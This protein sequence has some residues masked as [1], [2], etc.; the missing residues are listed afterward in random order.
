M[1]ED[2]NAIKS[3]PSSARQRNAIEM[4]FRWRAFN[5]PSLNTVLVAMYFLQRAVQ[6]QSNQGLVILAGLG[7]FSVF[8]PIINI[9]RTD[10][11]SLLKTYAVFAHAHISCVGK[12]KKLVWV[13]SFD[14]V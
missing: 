9:E 10:F 11:T 14:Q 6:P 5:G 8:D 7:C 4:A 2:R 13:L 12:Q 1:E 3:W